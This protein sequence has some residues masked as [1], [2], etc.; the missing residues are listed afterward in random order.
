VS[1]FLQDVGG[2]KHHPLRICHQISEM[3]TP[4]QMI[5]PEM[6]S[7]EAAYSEKLKKKIAEA[8]KPVYFEYD[9]YRLTNDAIRQLGKVVRLLQEESKLRI[10]IQGNCD[11][12]GILR[13][14][15]WAGRTARDGDQRVSCNVWNKKYK[16]R[17]D[18]FRQGDACS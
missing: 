7:G 17:N 2:K 6:V 5:V 8:L 13:I 16:N 15:C 1:F 10:I 3:L 11:E 18:I 14:L 12:R 9:S 4:S